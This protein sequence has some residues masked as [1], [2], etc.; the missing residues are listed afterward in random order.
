MHYFSE[1]EMNRRLGKLRQAME[2]NQ[3]DAVVVTS[4][5]NT[6][7]YSNYWMIP[8]GREQGIVVPRTGEPAL[9]APRIEYDRPAK[10]SFLD[11][12]RIYWDVTS[13]ID[14]MVLLIQEVLRDHDITEG[15]LG[16]EEDSISVAL[17]NS[18][19]SALPKFEFVDMGYSMM[20][21]Q[22]VK[23]QEEI[24]LIR[25]GA[26]ICD[27]GAQAF[28][29]AVTEGIT[30]VQLARESVTAMEEEICRRFPSYECDGTF[31]WA[32]S[33]PEHTK[34]A[35]ALNTDRQIQ[36]GDLLSLNVFP[37]ILGYYHLLER[38]LVF[39]PISDEVRKF[40]EIQVEVHQAGIESLQPG[41][42]LGDIDDTVINPIYKHYGLVKHRTFGTGHSFG[43][44]G[45]WYGRDELGEIRPYNDYVLQPNM[46][47]SMEPMIAVDGIGGFKHADMFLITENGNE[48]L[49][50]FPN[51][52]IV[53]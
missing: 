46:V 17:Q 18:L 15:R 28:T 44:M 42:R 11:D 37:M 24:T 12:I 45:Y 38:S 26:E 50:I 35:H 2:T 36:K 40:F 29:D 34:I 14:G 48:R 13:A 9:I 47:M 52:V 25:H 16:V 33:G 49:T 30:E 31:C 19:Q 23:S 41:V 7:Y 21:E 53:I 3:V 20:A 32:Q 39:G 1:V 51:D 6:L 8:W 4:V 5:H 43:I 27:I 10:M 22:M